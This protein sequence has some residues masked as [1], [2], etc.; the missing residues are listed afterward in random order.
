MKLYAVDW[1][2]TRGLTV[3][4]GKGLY[5]IE[6]KV[7]LSRLA[8]E[9]FVALQSKTSVNPASQVAE[10]ESTSYVKSKTRLTPSAPLVILEQGCPLSLIHDIL[11]TGSQVRLINNH[12]TEEHRR[13]YNI[14]KSDET[15]AK[16]IYELAN[17][18]AT[19]TPIS[20][21]DSQM[22]LFD[23]YHRYKRYQKARVAMQN[24]R[25]AYIRHFGNRESKRAVHSRG[26]LNLFPTI[27]ER[28]KSTCG[29][30]S[31]LE[32]NPSLSDGKVPYDISINVLKVAENSVLK[33]IVKLS[34][35]IP[36]SLKI[37]GLGPRLW[38]G[39]FITAN[40]IN[41]LSL[42]S[43]LRYCGL[44]NP[45]QLNHKWNRHAKMLYHLLAEEVM[46]HRDETFRPVYDQCKKDIAD[47]HPEYSKKHIHNAAL[48]RTATFL[49]KH[50]F[51]E[52][53]A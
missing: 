45:D 27:R 38:A 19:L 33:R 53:R 32:F 42:S 2:H 26:W 5:K 48:N 50:I 7:L 6:R 31:T 34:P 35:P 46:K 24:M 20:L 21:S 40:P 49:A 17:N 12:A 14:D 15:D 37:R 43:Y 9:S 47:R 41:F 23:L 16:I 22:Q 25:K 18:G 1:S 36:S 39:I 30:S 3:F 52:V 13:Q 11:K 29:F 8:R 51:K 10:G 44:I 28:G 4:D